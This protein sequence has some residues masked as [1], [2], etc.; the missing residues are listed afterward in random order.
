[1]SCSALVVYGNLGCKKSWDDLVLFLLFVHGI[2]KVLNILRKMC[3][4]SLIL[5]QTVMWSVTKEMNRFCKPQPNTHLTG[6][7]F[8]YPVGLWRL[9]IQLTPSIR[10]RE[11]GLQR[12][13]PIPNNWIVGS[14][15]PGLSVDFCV[16]FRTSESASI[17]MSWSQH[18]KLL[19]LF[20]TYVAMRTKGP[21]NWWQSW[22]HCI[23]VSGEQR[24]PLSFGE[25][26][27][28]IFIVKAQKKKKT[29]A[30]EILTP[31]TWFLH[32]K[33]M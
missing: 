32:F 26:V 18:R 17:K 14:A 20:I 22:A 11:V 13:G 24:T 27:A 8:L 23:S 28:W 7:S 6:C 1:M 15:L 9:T 5:L 3:A 10:G 19:K 31:F 21:L 30:S 12:E 4:V 25:K 29:K 2:V 33:S 16:C